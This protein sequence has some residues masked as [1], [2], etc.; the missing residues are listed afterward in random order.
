MSLLHLDEKSKSWPPIMEQL[1]SPTQSGHN[2]TIG[3]TLGKA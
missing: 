3:T 1:L 2:R